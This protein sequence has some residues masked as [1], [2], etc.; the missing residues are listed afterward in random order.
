MDNTCE[1]FTV[2]FICL[3]LG[4]SF[5][6]SLARLCFHVLLLLSIHL[7]VSD[8]VVFDLS[9]ST[10]SQDFTG[11]SLCAMTYFVSTGMKNLKAL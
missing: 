10:S 5:Y 8:F 7:S 1:Q 2:I 11:K 6:F 3:A 9:L 4:F